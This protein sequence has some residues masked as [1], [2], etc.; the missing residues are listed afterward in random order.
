MWCSLRLSTPQATILKLWLC[1]LCKPAIRTEKKN[2]LS[3]RS[4]ELSQSTT[5]HIGIMADIQK[6]PFVKELASSGMIPFGL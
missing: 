6:T 1:K 2:D 4:T 5:I 3:P